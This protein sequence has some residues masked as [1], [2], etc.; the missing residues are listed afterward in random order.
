[1]PEPLTLKYA[2]SKAALNNSPELM[3]YSAQ[4]Q[5]ALAEQDLALSK[6][7]FFAEINGRLR[8][9]DPSSI[10]PASETNDSK[11]SL[12]ISKRL[13]DFGRSNANIEASNKMLDS[14]NA[15]YTVTIS[16]NTFNIAG[17]FKCVISRYCLCPC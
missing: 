2:L 1:M 8:Y 9:V 17:L 12:D 3:S 16:N 4:K 10:V 14:V 13:Y 5:I 7:G 6:T 11:I 15:L